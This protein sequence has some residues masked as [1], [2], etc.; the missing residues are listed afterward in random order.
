MTSNGVECVPLE[1]RGFCLEGEL[2][3]PLTTVLTAALMLLSK[4]RM[5]KYCSSPCL[6]VRMAR[7]AQTAFLRSIVNCTVKPLV[8]R[9]VNNLLSN[10][11]PLSQ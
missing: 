9:S 5:V 2:L 7:S 4:G 6:K 10:S 11:D 3:C 1:W 8:D